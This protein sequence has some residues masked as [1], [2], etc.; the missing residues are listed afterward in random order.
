MIRYGRR[1]RSR[2]SAGG[3]GLGELF[4]A[5]PDLA[6]AAALVSCC[7]RPL[8]QLPFRRTEETSARRRS[9]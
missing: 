5:L 9:R 3:V 1:R 4:G 2:R 8:S 6:I 7:K